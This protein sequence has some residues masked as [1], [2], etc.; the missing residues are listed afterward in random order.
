MYDFDLLSSNDF[1]G[2]ALFDLTVHNM[3]KKCYYRKKSV[4]LKLKEFINGK[5]GEKTDKIWVYLFE[6]FP[7]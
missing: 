2:G 5:P 6:K 7:H 4:K 3:L 1:I